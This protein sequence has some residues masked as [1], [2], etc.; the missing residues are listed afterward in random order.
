MR[1]LIQRVTHA[2]VS[3]PDATTQSIE[4]GFCILLG[5]GPTDTKEIAE[6]LWNKIY[7]LRIFEDTQGKTN[8]SLSDV[9]GSALIVSQFTLYADCK[10]GNRPSFTK[11]AAPSL[12][13]ELY[14][15]FLYCA[16]KSDVPIKAG[17]F[18]AMMKLHIV[19][20]GP[21]TLWLDTEELF[22]HMHS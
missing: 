22:P 19:N 17:W 11:S 2:S 1:A 3:A 12:A 4:K 5:V 21:F 9:G 10:K 16:S 18:G 20:D 14:N 6:A 7:K 13:E 8:Q 15:H